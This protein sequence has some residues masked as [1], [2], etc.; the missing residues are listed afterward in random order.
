[1]GHFLQP[2]QAA[3]D[4]LLLREPDGKL[5]PML[6]TAWKYNDDQHQAHR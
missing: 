1:M 3:Y 2:Y 4:S 6:A 5:S